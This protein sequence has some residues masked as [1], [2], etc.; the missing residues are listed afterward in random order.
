MT[1]PDPLTSPECDLR[2]YEYMPLLGQRLYGS[3]F[4]SLALQNPRAGLAAQKL[5]WEAWQQCP[6]GSLPAD[7][8][9]LC[10][11]ADFGTDLRSWAKA[12]GIALH[13]FV[14]C[15]DGRLYHPI[16][17]EQAIHAHAKRIKGRD[18]KARWRA[19]RDGDGTHGPDSVPRDTT[20]DTTET[21]PSRNV[22]TGQVQDR[23]G[24][25][26]RK[27]PPIAPPLGGREVAKRFRQ[28]DKVNGYV[29]AARLLAAEYE[30]E[31]AADAKPH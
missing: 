26:E 3:A 16:I 12:K 30:A 29:E 28:R 19:S 25:E 8:F 1:R 11:L 21:E 22:L 5:W 15:S 14:L 6:A 2:G 10:R 7:D 17:C 9:T 31:E 13:G 24:T 18:R 20:R 4:Y 27:K 23:T